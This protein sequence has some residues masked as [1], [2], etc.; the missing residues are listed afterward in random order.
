MPYSSIFTTAGIA[1][2]S[3]AISAGSAVNLTHMAVGDGNGAEV[4]PLASQT[5]LVR[6][7]WR[8]GRK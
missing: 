1:K 4:N 3:A 5:A 8:G 2:L 7:V 6:E